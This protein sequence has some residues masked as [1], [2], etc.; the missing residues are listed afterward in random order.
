MKKHYRS[1]RSTDIK[2]RLYTHSH[3]KEFLSNPTIMH[4]YLTVAS[5]VTPRHPRRQDTATTRVLG[6]LNEFT[7]Y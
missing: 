7:E 6:A 1:V 3:Q 5:C 2:V 4:L